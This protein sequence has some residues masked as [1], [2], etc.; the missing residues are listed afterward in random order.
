MRSLQHTSAPRCCPFAQLRG[1]AAPRALA[2]RQPVRCAVTP[3]R[4]QQQQSGAAASSQDVVPL[5]QQQLDAILPQPDDAA[6][7]QAGPRSAPARPQ[8]QPTQQSVVTASYDQMLSNWAEQYQMP[9]EMSLWDEDGRRFSSARDIQ[10]AYLPPK[11]DLPGLAVALSI[12]GCWVRLL[13][14]L[15]LSCSVCA[16]AVLCVRVS[17]AAAATRACLGGGGERMA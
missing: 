11:S 8:P 3:T 7:A 13:L 10:L 12:I 2:R 17:T 4:P 15:S 14:L 6:A 9:A 5:S 1:G 16:L